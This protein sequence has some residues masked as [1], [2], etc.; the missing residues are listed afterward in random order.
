[1][2]LRDQL[3]SLY[4]R[5]TRKHQHSTPPCLHQIKQVVRVSAVSIPLAVLIG[6]SEECVYRGFLPLILAAKTRLPL[7][8][9]VGIPAVCCGVRR[10]RYTSTCICFHGCLVRVTASTHGT[11]HFQ[12]CFTRCCC[13]VHYPSEI[14]CTI[15]FFFFN[16]HYPAQ[17]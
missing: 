10:S 7:I 12:A 2:F 11:E 1:M 14:T 17:A 5:M 13:Q 9:I 3:C 15:A 8:A 16:S 6:F 4:R